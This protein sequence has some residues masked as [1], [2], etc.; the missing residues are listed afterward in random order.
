[1]KTYELNGRLFKFPDDKVP[2]GAKLH[3]KAPVKKEQK[4]AEPA[5]KETVEEAKPKAKKAPANKARKAGA[6]K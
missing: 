1:M 6:N 4:E 2:A 3:T 5:A